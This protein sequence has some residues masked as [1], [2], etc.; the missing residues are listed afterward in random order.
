MSSRRLRWLPPALLIAIALNQLR[1]VYTSDLTPWCGGGFGMFSTTD[2]RSARHL[3]AYAMSPGLVLE[4]EV[5]I[6]L[7]QR[8]AAALALPGEARLRALAA[9]LAPKP[10]SE[11]E[12]PESLRIDVFATRWHR[13]T[14]AP[15]GA[16]VRSVEVPLA[17]P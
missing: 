7:G 6:E 3:H 5:P 9:D 14:L 12:P 16:L 11:L 8:A 4:L 15:T 17:R 2:G 13:A 1:L 10:G